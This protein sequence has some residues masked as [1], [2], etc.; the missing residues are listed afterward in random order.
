MNEVYTDL[1]NKTKNMERNSNLYGWIFTY[2]PFDKVWSATE[3]D[4]YNA[5]F[6]GYNDRVLR[7]ANIVTLQEIIN[8]TAGDKNKIKKLLKTK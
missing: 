4:N 8:K 7:S 5:L 6:N 1:E 2:N 3:R